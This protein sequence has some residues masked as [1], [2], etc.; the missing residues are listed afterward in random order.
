MFMLRGRDVEL[1]CFSELLKS[2]AATGCG[3]AVSV[4]GDAGMGKT[5]LLAEMA[6]AAQA[7]GFRV[8]RV[9]LDDEVRS[10]LGRLPGDAD[11]TATGLRAAPEGRPARGPVL[12]VMD[13]LRWSESTAS[14]LEKLFVQLTT[15]PVVCLMAYRVGRQ[16]YKRNGMD[17]GGRQSLL[18]LR[19]RGRMEAGSRV[20]AAARPVCGAQVRRAAHTVR[21]VRTARSSRR[22][23]LWGPSVWSSRSSAARSSAGSASAP[24]SRMCRKPLSA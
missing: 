7:L 17:R 21:S 20:L 2:V 15:Q 18:G 22:R 11:A 13:N 5:A 8:A 9:G 4:E 12:V 24:A 6:A 19:F 16:G 14:T 10:E 3:V 1:A 23:M